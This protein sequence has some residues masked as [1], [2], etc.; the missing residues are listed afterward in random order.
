MKAAGIVMAA[1]AAVAYAQNGSTYLALGDSV[2]YGM[3]V[4]LVPPYA[5]PT[6]HPA[7]TQFV[8]YPQA[9]AASQG[10]D[11]SQLVDKSC[12][13]ETSGSLLN[14]L[15]PDN[16]CNSVH[17]VRTTMGSFLLTVINPPLTP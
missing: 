11:A 4:T 15:L 16:R 2:A 5:P 12:P 6:P 9:L 7:P 14:S 13:G 1:F 3:N 8:G 10:L 17:A